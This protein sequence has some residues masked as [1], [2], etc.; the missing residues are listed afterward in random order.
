[1]EDNH[2]TTLLHAAICHRGYELAKL[3]ALYAQSSDFEKINDQGHTPLHRAILYGFDEVVDIYFST[4]HAYSNVQL[5]DS[6]LLYAIECERELMALEI[7]RFGGQQI[8]AILQH[9][10]L[11]HT[12]RGGNDTTIRKVLRQM[13]TI[14]Y[15]DFLTAVAYNRSNALL[16][17]WSHLNTKEQINLGDLLIYAIQHKN[18]TYDIIIVLLYH[19]HADPCYTKYGRT[20]LSYAAEF[21]PEII[22][23]LL[24]NQQV[25]PSLSDKYGRTP[26]EYALATPFCSEDILELLAL[27]YRMTPSSFDDRGQRIMASLWNG[28]ASRR[29][30]HKQLQKRDFRI[31]RRTASQ[32]TKG[33]ITPQRTNKYNLR[34]QQQR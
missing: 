28:N 14:D 19:L 24:R 9:T 15:E 25:N 34:S 12:I 8:D 1:M 3:L 32:R 17:L 6:L 23:E 31:T 11:Q 33:S 21:K 20:A 2:Y 16:F 30:L 10:F 18:T 4:T 7:L 26:L 5:M 13:T 22:P 27:D 29:R